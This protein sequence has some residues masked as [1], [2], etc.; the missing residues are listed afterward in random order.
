MT[1][2]WFT[3]AALQVAQPSLALPVGCSLTERCAIQSLADRAAGPDRADYRC[4]KLATEGHDGIDFRLRRFTDLALSARVLAAADGTVLRVRDGMTDRNI[5]VAGAGDMGDRWAGNGVVIDHGGGWQTQ[6]SHLKQG[7]VGVRPGQVVRAGDP[8]GLIGMSGNAEFPHLHFTVRRGDEAI[9]PF[10]ARPVAAKPMC[11][12][13]GRG[14]WRDPAAA[15]WVRANEILAIGFAVDGADARARRIA[16]APTPMPADPAT[17]VLWA[18]VAG[19][20][21]GAMERY[22]LRA[23]DGRI[24]VSREARQPTGYVSWFGFSG[25]RRP[26][27][28][29][30]HGEY[31]ATYT[32][33]AKG[34]VQKATASLILR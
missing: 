34:I 30:P 21:A 6:Y 19:L 3:S 9:D 22:E 26:A 17:L 18:D 25:T 29:W 12:A 13:S 28:G 16:T 32:V 15:G 31:F 8:L 4:R 33:E 11:G 10:D 2:W 27:G 24:M 14:L 5:R 23:P 7:S 1:W 20:E